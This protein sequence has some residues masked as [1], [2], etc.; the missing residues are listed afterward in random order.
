[1]RY[2]VSRT[3]ILFVLHN[4]LFSSRAI[5]RLTLEVSCLGTHQ[6]PRSGARHNR[7]HMAMITKCAKCRRAEPNRNPVQAR[8]YEALTGSAPRAHSR[9]R[10]YSS[11]DTLNRL[12]ILY[13]SHNRC[14]EATVACGMP[15]VPVCLAD[16]CRGFSL[17]SIGLTC[18]G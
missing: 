14:D 16:S 9:V 5:P 4:I 2:F 1:V 12:T 6:L 3:L 15:C 17:R 10:Q 13:Q 7:F 8:G 18:I 11:A